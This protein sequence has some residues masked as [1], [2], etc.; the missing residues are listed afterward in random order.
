VTS[1]PCEARPRQPGRLVIGGTASGVGKTTVTA[2]VLAAL[3]ARGLSLAPFKVGPDYI[4]PTYHSQAAGRACRNLDSWLVPH[5]R[6]LA[7]F[8]RATTGT[9]VALVEG[10]MGL[11]DGRSGA[12][13]AGSTAE[14]AVLLRAPIV[15]VLDIARQARSAAALALGF[16]RFDPAVPLAGFILNR[17]G[18]ARHTDLVR[19]EVEHATGLPVLGAMPRDAG[20]ELPERHLGLTP[21]QEVEQSL[22]TVERLADAARL[23]LDLNRL[24]ELAG[25]APPL[26]AAADELLGLANQ[27]PGERRCLAI[28]RDEAFSF[29][30]QDNLD[31]L[32]LAGARLLPFSPLG[33]DE[34]PL[35]AEGLYLGGGFPELHAERLAANT[36]MLRSVRRAAEAGLPIYAEC[37]GLMY[38]AEGIVDFDGQQHAMSGLIPCS[39]GMQPRRSRL[40]YVELEARRQTLLSAAGARL[41][42]HEF[43][44]SAIVSGQERAN[45][46][47]VLGEEPRIEG[48]ARKSLLASYVHLHF[49]SAPELAERFV[50][51]LGA[52]RTA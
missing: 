44:W 46:Y 37:G 10:V 33:D 40:G 50:G 45:A 25:S 16:Q 13:N 8:S 23:H 9:D 52:A 48:F 28:A 30:Y 35:E 24:T 27:S 1:S 43:H 20:L 4:D 41:R 38:L 18:S 47:Q 42:G 51:S 39:V 12:G 19:K 15:L 6:L 36:A 7:L 14:V 34:L 11:F 32:E 49:G 17:A 26:P 5:E 22:A 31:L 3:T 29:Y 2:A 21:S